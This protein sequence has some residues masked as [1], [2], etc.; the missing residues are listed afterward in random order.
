MGSLVPFQH[1]NLCPEPQ[2]IATSSAVNTSTFTTSTNNISG[3]TTFNFLTPKLE[4][5][6]EP[7]DELIPTQ[8]IHQQ[9]NFLFSV[10]NS[11]PDF[12]PIPET[13]PQSNVSPSTDDQNALYSEYFRI[14]ELFRSDFAERIRKYGDVAVLDPDSRAIVPVPEQSQL[15]SETSPTDSSHPERALSVVVSRKKAGRSNELVRV[16]NLGIEDQLHFRDLVLRTRLLYDALR[17]LVGSEEEKRTG[18]G[19]GRR[20]RGDLRAAGVMRDRELWLNRDKRIVGALPGIE[21]G[22]V[23]FLR[24][25]LCVVGLHGHNQA[26]IDTLPASQ[27]SNG[28]PIATS[29]IISGGYE[30]DE[31]SGSS[32]I[33]TGQ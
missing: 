31:D 10:S 15:T 6:Q 17:I 33:Y 30:D 24:M 3:T 4:P 22:D 18:P 9:E 20:A 28:E 12:I 29:I 23:F 1:L 13:I 8:T 25:E 21:I 11:T 5:K 7:F 16:A 26:G 14:S 2:L 27:S 19:H 32:V